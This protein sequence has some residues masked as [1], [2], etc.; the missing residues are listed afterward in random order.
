VIDSAVM[1][2]GYPLYTKYRLTLLR[3]A[4]QIDYPEA[5]TVSYRSG[6]F[7]WTLSFDLDSLF[8]GF[9]DRSRWKGMNQYNYTLYQFG[10]LA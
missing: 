9:D 4:T 6:L 1:G 2:V 5:R 3:L 8:V 10:S 7:L